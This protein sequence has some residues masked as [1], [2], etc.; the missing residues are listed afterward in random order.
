MLALN[1]NILEIYK[2]VQKCI[3]NEYGYT[4]NAMLRFQHF[5]ISDIKQEKKENENMQVL[6]L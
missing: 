4:I 2:I 3:K 6:L 1:C 5:L